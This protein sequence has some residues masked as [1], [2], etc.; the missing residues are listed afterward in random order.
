[1][2]SKDSLGEGDTDYG[3]SFLPETE[4]FWNQAIY[5]SVE[6]DGLLPPYGPHDSNCSSYVGAKHKL[7]VKIETI[8]ISVVGVFLPTVWLAMPRRHDDMIIFC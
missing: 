3:L 1:M 8:K 4:A 7:S 5:Q 6:N 2:K